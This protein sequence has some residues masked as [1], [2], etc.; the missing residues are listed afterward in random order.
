MRIA[1]YCEAF[2]GCF[3]ENIQCRLLLRVIENGNMFKKIRLVQQE[4]VMTSST[5]GRM[6]TSLLSVFLTVGSFPK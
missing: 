1:L 4:T 6:E 2:N 5:D 3:P